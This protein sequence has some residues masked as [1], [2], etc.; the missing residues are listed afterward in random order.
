MREEV[1][2]QIKIWSFM[3]LIGFAV[4]GMLSFFTEDEQNT[5]IIDKSLPENIRSIQ[6][7]QITWDN[8]ALYDSTQFNNATNICTAERYGM[9]ITISPCIAY[10]VDGRAIEQNVKFKWGGANQRNISWIFVY[11][12][13]LDS[14][15][16]SALVNQSRTIQDY[17]NTWVN[18]YL[19]DR[20]SS[21]ANLTSTPASCDLGN[22][23]N[24]QFYRVSRTYQN[25]T[26]YNQTICFTTLAVVNATAFRISGNADLLQDKIIYEQKY[27]DVTNQI[28]YLGKGLLNDNRSYYKIEDVSFSP[29]QTIDTKWI[30][31]PKDATKRGKW[32]IL[33]YDTQTGLV[34]SVVNNEYIYIDPWWSSSWSKKKQVTNLTGSIVDIKIDYDSD[35]Q[36]DYDDI[37]WINSA[38]TTELVYVK[39]FSNSTTAIYKVRTDGATSM[40]LYYGNAGASY[41]GNIA[42]VY[43]ANTI[44]AWFFEGNY[45]DI[46]SP[47]N[48]NATNNSIYIGNSDNN[49]SY[50]TSHANASAGNS[51]AVVT[52]ITDPSEFSWIV[53]GKRVADGSLVSWRDAGSSTLKFLRWENSGANIVNQIGTGSGYS[54]NSLV[55]SDSTNWHFYYGGAKTTGNMVCF[56][57]ANTCQNQTLA[58]V[59]NSVDELDMMALYSG[60]YQNE[61]SG[62]IDDLVLFDRVLTSLEINTYSNQTKPNAI[63]GAETVSEGL[64]VALNS[65]ANAYSS[66]DTLVTFNFTITPSSI[67]ITNWTLLVYYA[68]NS[69][70]HQH[71]LAINTN[72]T[73]STTH[74]DTLFNENS[75]VWNVKACGYSS[76]TSTTFCEFGTNRTFEI[77][78]SAPSFT[79]NSL[80]NVTTLTLPT[81]NTFNV[82]TSDP[83]IN[84]CQYWTSDSATRFSYTCNTT[85]LIN[86]TTGGTKT[87]YIWAN[88]TT[89]N[90]NQTS[91]NFNI[92]DFN[93]SQR[94]NADPIAEGST[95]E[96]YL[97]INSTS[98]PIGD[99][100][101]IITFNATQHPATTKTVID[102]NTIEFLYSFPV[103]AGLGNATGKPY[104]YNW[105]YNTTQLSTRT[106]PTTTQTIISFAIDGCSVYTVQIANFTLKDEEQ[107]T[108]LFVVNSTATLLE[109][110]ALVTSNTYSGITWSY[111][112]TFTNSTSVRLCVPSGVLN[113][114]NFTIDMTLGFEGTNHVREFWYLDNGTLSLTSPF[115]SITPNNNSLIDLLTLDSTTF[116]FEFTDENGLEVPDAI[117]HVFRK[118]IGEGLFR[119]VERA[120]QDV[121]GQTH[122]HLVEEDVIYYFVVTQNG[123]IIYTSETYNAKCLSSPCEISL[124][125]N[126]TSVDWTI[127]DNEGGQYSVSA[128]KDTRIVTTQFSLSS[129]DL[130]N[131]SLYELDDGI[132]KLVNQ[133]SLTATA[134]SIP[135]NVPLA[136]GN[137]T[138]F[139]A[140]Y[141]DNQFVKSE[142]V[143]LTDRGRDYFGTT[144]AIF[145]GLIVLA[146]ML[147]AVTEGVGFIVFTLFALIIIG[148]M[149]LVDLGW[150]SLISIICAGGIIIFKLVKRRQQA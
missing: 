40:Y 99:A 70:A 80:P 109:I 122:V 85:Q 95:S 91:Y 92:Y 5:V 58:G 118:Y 71:F 45:G 33:G 64:S 49:V 59:G 124:S 94:E 74:N 138:F 62:Q 144:G 7:P 60:A 6:S 93:V 117:V 116:L 61:M 141:N 142:W 52:S 132:M 123:Q 145:G 50:F 11:D 48:H 97:R 112:Q 63:F 120:R 135:L 134:G 43:N 125:A 139:V 29:N 36:T 9:N 131:V 114:A 65:P 55:I 103:V 8:V 137:K 44:G 119:E 53:F 19:V 32:H 136:Y 14:G 4:I 35:M 46:V 21:Y 88:D 17:Q 129:I 18:N 133:S 31:T 90:S 86:F 115:N 37:R 150:M 23:N 96:L 77:H 89:G 2:R 51:R 42:T 140:I 81:N 147:M 3:L 111:A 15:S 26:A 27:V 66:N 126:P 83:K 13:A 106:T 67:N 104:L 84:T 148:V 38:E 82:T 146:I 110:E 1:K 102:A 128:N 72:V 22:L 143:D 76:G 25:N 69:I 87:L 108:N 12:Y 68:N 10:D 107:N 98:F 56:N 24:T 30:Y 54:I 101:A 105:T 113:N 28:Q 20:V 47:A 73:Y 39:I 78:T 100:S 127:I 79:L 121:N 41:T 34:N 130:V 57:S 75:Y 16:I 149:K